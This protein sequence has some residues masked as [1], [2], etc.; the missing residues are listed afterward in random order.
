M[1]F[2]TAA[3]VD[4]DLAKYTV[5]L[6]KVST[7]AA[8]LGSTAMP[9]PAGEPDY[10][11]L[12]WAEHPYAATDTAFGSNLGTK[13]HRVAFDIRSMRK[14]T[15]RETLAFVVQYSDISGAPPL[16]FIGAQTR[17]LTTLH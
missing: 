7:D 15:T 17:V 12:Y 13:V 3:G 6:G 11:W 4:G 2:P 14:F 16:T 1:F 9:D 8:T 5:G 10:P